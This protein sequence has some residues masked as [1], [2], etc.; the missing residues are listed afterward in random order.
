MIFKIIF[1]SECCTAAAAA[2]DAVVCF[3]NYFHVLTCVGT[4][5][6]GARRVVAVVTPAAAAWLTRS[7]ENIY[8]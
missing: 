4:Y 1:I 8:Y 2:D 6:P 7:R 3:N 5:V